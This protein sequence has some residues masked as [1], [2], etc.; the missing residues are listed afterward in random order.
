MNPRTIPRACVGTQS[1]TLLLVAAGATPSS[2]CAMIHVYNSPPPPP[3]LP[4]VPGM[5]FPFYHGYVLIGLSTTSTGFMVTSPVPLAPQ[6]VRL[7]PDSGLGSSSGH[8]APTAGT[9]AAHKPPTEHPFGP[10][11]DT[12]SLFNAYLNPDDS[13]MLNM[14]FPVPN[15]FIHEP[16]KWTILT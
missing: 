5:V 10:P 2:T 15:S 4:L 8:F 6:F 9:V 14:N 11:E 13:T 16:R 1:T 7:G 3:P 12:H